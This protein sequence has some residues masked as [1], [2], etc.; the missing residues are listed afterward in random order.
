[1]PTPTFV[2]Y[3]EEQINILDMWT[4]KYDAEQPLTAIYLSEARRALQKALEWAEKG[5]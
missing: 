5:K 4:Q 1:M 2:D 3:L